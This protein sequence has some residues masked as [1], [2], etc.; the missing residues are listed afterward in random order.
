MLPSWGWPLR[1]GRPCVVRRLWW[2]RS[3]RVYRNKPRKV[4]DATKL[5][6]TYESWEALC[7]EEVMVDE[8][9]KSLQEQA[10]KGKWCYQAGGDLWE[11]GGPVSWGGHGGR[12]HQES[13]GTSQEGLVRPPSWGWLL[14]AGRPCDMRRSWWTRSSRVYRNKPRRVSDA[15]KLGVTFESWEALC[16]LRRSWWLRS[17]KVCR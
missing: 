9:I 16:V 15:T 8:V 17:S 4:S 11:L 1:A 7:H 3:S 2:L 5:G 10:K 14:R 6:V 12:G 13:T